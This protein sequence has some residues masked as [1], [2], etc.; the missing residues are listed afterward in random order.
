[1]ITQAN[2]RTAILNY[3]VLNAKI[4]ILTDSIARFEYRTLADTLAAK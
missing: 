4:T 1:M 3:E 2:W